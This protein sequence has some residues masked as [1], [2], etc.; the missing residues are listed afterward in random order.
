MLGVEE[1]EVF[2]HNLRVF[3]WEFDD[4]GLALD[5]IFLQGGFEVIRRASEEELVDDERPL[6]WADEEGD[7]VILVEGDCV[8]RGGRVGG[9][10]GEF[11]FL[12]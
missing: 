11:A 1:D 6:V 8:R 9:R 7:H 2:V 12:L 10:H 5:P 4:A 3:L